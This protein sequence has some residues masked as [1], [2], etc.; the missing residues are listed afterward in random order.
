[1][2]QP[3]KPTMKM[4]HFLTRQQVFDQAALHLLSQGHAGLPPR[5]GSAYRGY[6]GGCPVGHFISPRDHITAMEG[7]PVLFI[8][9]ASHTAPSYMEAGITALKRALLR[10]QINVYDPSTIELLS[11]LQ[12]VHD[13]TDT[14]EWR[15]RLKPIAHQ[16]GLCAE[17]LERAA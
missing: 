2:R 8:G 1:M 13:V 5:G 7:G 16:F 4:L 3:G 14:W 9:A 17:L 15:D 6:C 10:S 12:S 11:C